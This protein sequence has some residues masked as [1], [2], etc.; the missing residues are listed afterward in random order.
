MVTEN[1]AL[2]LARGLLEKESIAGARFLGSRKLQQQ[3]RD[4]WLL[5]FENPDPDPEWDLGLDELVV[6]VDQRNGKVRFYTRL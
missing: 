4:Y 5:V 2:C 3:G 1:E 6:Q